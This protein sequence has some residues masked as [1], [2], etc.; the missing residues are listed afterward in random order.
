MKLF[1]DTADQKSI[2]KLK[3]WGVVDG[4]T[5][6]PSIMVKC[7]AKTQE[8]MTDRAR[9][10]AASIAPAPLSVEV[11][12]DDVDEMIEQGQALAAIADNVAVKIPITTTTGESCL[13]AVCALAR[14]DIAVNVTAMMT[15][16]QLMLAAK[17]G[18]RYLSLFGGRIDDEG[19]DALQIISESKVWV[20]SAFNFEEEPEIIVGSVRTVKNVEEWAQAGADIITVT[21]DIL[22]KML[23]NART[24][25]TVAQFLDDGLAAMDG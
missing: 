4:V 11:V 8:E 2:E 17:A 7:G 1:L 23:V 21:P 14:R 10:I 19:S 18:A 20:L 15:F 25:E 22:E 6:N 3:G 13:P 9:W 16:N 12:T 5:T 24:K